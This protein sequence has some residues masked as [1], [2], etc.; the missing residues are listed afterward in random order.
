MIGKT[1]NPLELSEQVT[2]LHQTLEDLT[3]LGFTGY[4]RVDDEVASV[5][6]AVAELD[7]H[8]ATLYTAMVEQFGRDRLDHLIDNLE[9]Y[10]E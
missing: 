5:N 10:Y 2:D 3:P 9:E 6:A 8:L 7:K 4:E 1:V